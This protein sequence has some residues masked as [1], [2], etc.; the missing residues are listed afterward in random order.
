MSHSGPKKH[1]RLTEDPSIEDT[2]DLLGPRNICQTLNPEPQTLKQ[3]PKPEIH[4]LQSGHVRESLEGAET[5]ES[6][7]AEHVVTSR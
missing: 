6:R 5:P 3:N 4:A 7:H 1:L 2:W